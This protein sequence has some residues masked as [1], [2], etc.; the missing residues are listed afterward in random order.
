MWGS[1][2][3]IRQSLDLQWQPRAV[4]PCGLRS[5]SAPR[6]DPLPEVQPS[7]IEKALGAVVMTAL[8]GG[9]FFYPRGPRRMNVLPDPGHGARQVFITDDQPGETFWL[10]VAKDVV[11][12]A[13]A[14]GQVR[15]NS[16]GNGLID[17]QPTRDGL[18][19]DFVD[20]SYLVVHMSSSSKERVLHWF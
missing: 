10:A 6:R 3:R 19:L 16:V 14:T 13:D 9:G 20:K 18:R 4:E 11:A 2:R 8:F 7:G 5:P 1:R 15:W 17:M 12:I